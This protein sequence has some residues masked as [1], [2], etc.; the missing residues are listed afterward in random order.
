[1]SGGY[2]DY[3]QAGINDIAYDLKWLIKDQKEWNNHELNNKTL[4]EFKKGLVI[5][6]QAAVYAQR[7]DW[8]LSCDDGEDCFHRRLKEDLSKLNNKNNVSK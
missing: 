4:K 3:K 7:I 5:I 6:E 1:M 2:F 8:L